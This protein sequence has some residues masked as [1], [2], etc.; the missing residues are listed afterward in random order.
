MGEDRILMGSDY[1][2]PLGETEP[3][4]VIDE[5]AH[6]SELARTKLLSSNA[7]AFFSLV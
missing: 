6:L 2:F 1:P 5:S 4:Q 7:E 3:G